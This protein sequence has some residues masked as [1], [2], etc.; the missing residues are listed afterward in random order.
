M[1]KK[2]ELM[3]WVKRWEL[4]GPGCRLVTHSL[5]GPPG[6]WLESCVT[7]TRTQPAFISTRELRMYLATHIRI[8]RANKRKG[9]KKND[10][11][12]PKKKKEKRKKNKRKVLIEFLLQCRRFLT[13]RV[14]C[15]KENEWKIVLG[16]MWVRHDKNMMCV[17][18]LI[19][20]YFPMLSC[21]YGV[22]M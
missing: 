13:E 19:M 12:P 4:C 6:A 22:T 8:K 9:L 21:T 15:R 17:Q 10:I 7:P 2:C 14:S 18:G 5:K 11:A 20:F 3:R 1:W 16:F